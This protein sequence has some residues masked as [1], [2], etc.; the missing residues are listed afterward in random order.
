MNLKFTYLNNF[1]IKK[2]K[3]TVAY[4]I[5]TIFIVII[6]TTNSLKKNTNSLYPLSFKTLID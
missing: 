3:K 2:S 6:N 4:K 5:C 1:W